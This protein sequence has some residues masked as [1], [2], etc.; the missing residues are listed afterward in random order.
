MLH[1]VW[2]VGCREFRLCKVVISLVWIWTP[3]IRTKTSVSSN[4]LKHFKTS[5]FEDSWNRFCLTKD[6]SS[7]QNWTFSR[8]NLERRR[9][10]F[11]GKSKVCFA[12]SV[13]GWLTYAA[14]L[15]VGKRNSQSA[16][17]TR[18]MNICND[19]DQSTAAHRCKIVVNRW[20]QSFSLSREI[21][22]FLYLSLQLLEIAFDGSKGCWFLFW[23]KCRDRFIFEERSRNKS[24]WEVAHTV[25][26][27]SKIC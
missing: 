5:S 10:S 11:S 6:Q 15:Y 13:K 18:K 25:I 1:K 14:E 4:S 17:R 27:K 24:S 23:F 16:I 7:N 20:H 9:S 21:S 3:F 26:F 8:R 2:C 12:S 22:F 19:A